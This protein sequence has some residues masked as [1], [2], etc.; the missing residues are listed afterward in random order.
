MVESFYF[1][2]RSFTGTPEK[3][4]ANLLRSYRFLVSEYD[5]I[6][7][8]GLLAPAIDAMRGHFQLP[9][10]YSDQKNDRHS[11][12]E[13]CPVSG[14]RCPPRRFRGLPLKPPWVDLGLTDLLA[15]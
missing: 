3:K 13:V 5:R 6:L 15:A 7:R 2:P 4:L 1:L 11:H 14:E 10:E 8:E 12:L 9:T